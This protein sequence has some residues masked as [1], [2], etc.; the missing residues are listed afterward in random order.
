MSPVSPET[1]RLWGGAL[2]LDFA[3][4]VDYDAR[5]RPLPAHEALNAPGDLTRWARRLGVSRGR[6]LLAVDEEELGAALALRAAV[7]GVF[8]AIA[9]GQAPSPATLAR[10]AAAHADAAAHARLVAGGGDN[11]AAG[12]AWRLEWPARDPRR[13]RFAV[14][15]DAVALLGDPDRL[16]R[17]SRCPGRDCGWL[18]LD[19]SG[20]RRW[21]SMSACGSREKMRR[22]YARQRA[23]A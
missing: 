1:I 18:F 20:R 17:L 3:N 4:S 9:R 7:Y 6:R 5:D 19:T 12:R 8:A 16:A 11:G 21:C 14:A 13:V 15:T 2:C 10:V 23:R 22:M